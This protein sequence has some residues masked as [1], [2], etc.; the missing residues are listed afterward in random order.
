MDYFNA[1]VDWYYAQMYFGFYAVV[2]ATLYTRSEPVN[3]ALIARVLCGVN[4][5]ISVD[6]LLRNYET[7]VASTI[8][9]KL[10]I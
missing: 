6:T 4:F 8:S 9:I 10:Q 1:R 7:C 3:G 2:T 5:R